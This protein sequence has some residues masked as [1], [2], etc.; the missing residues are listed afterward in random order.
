MYV[1][2]K[3]KKAIEVQGKLRTFH[4]GDWVE[5]GKQDA[6]AWISEGS[7]EIFDG[8][9][10]LGLAGTD[11]CGIVVTGDRAAAEAKLGELTIVPVVYGKPMLR[12]ERT[13]LW[14]PAAMLVRNLVAVGFHLLGRWEVAVPLLD[15]GTLAAHIGTEEERKRTAGVVHDLRI[16]VYDTRLIYARRCGGTQRLLAAWRKE[17]KNDG[18]ERLAFLRALYRVKPLI[19]ALPITWTG[20]RVMGEQ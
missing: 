2:L 17:Q 4:P 15:Y 10:F 9:E 11:S 3:G 1:R 13:L 18:D 14:D 16:P 7:A 5:V 19:L 6:L 8:G 20:G 12:W